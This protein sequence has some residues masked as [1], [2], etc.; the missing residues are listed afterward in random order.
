MR[1]ARR[2]A[3]LIAPAPAAPSQVLFPEV[4]RLTLAAVPPAPHAGS[5]AGADLG[6]AARA[7][8]S[9]CQR[10]HSEEV[11]LFEELGRLLADVRALARRGRRE[12]GGMLGQLVDA[13]RRVCSAISAHIKREESDVLPLLAA[14]LPPQEQRAMV[15]HTLRAMPLR[16]LERVMPWL[17][18][19]LSPADADGLTSS[20]RL[21]APEGDRQVVELLLRW[22]QRGRWASE[23]A[24]GG[25]GGAAAA[26]TGRRASGDG[27]SD[28]S[29]S[30]EVASGSG[31]DGG[32]AGSED[33]GMFAINT[34]G[35]RG[36]GGDG[37]DAPAL[38]KRARGSSG[39]GSGGPGP[40]GGDSGLAAMRPRWLVE[41]HAH[42]H[43]GGCN[44]GTAAAA[45]TDAGGQAGGS[46]A[47]AAAGDSG[48]AASVPE[49]QQQAAA[50]SGPG[51]TLGPK[52][53]SRQR[54]GGG[55][56]GSPRTR[57]PVAAPAQPPPLPPPPRASP[58]G[59][60]KER[61]ASAGVSPIDHIFQF[62]KALRQELR[63]LE[64]DA[65]ELEG[66]VFS[67]PVCGAARQPG[68]GFR[69]RYAG[70][71]QQLDGRFQFLRGIY[72]CGQGLPSP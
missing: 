8:C 11:S 55:G 31:E 32:G 13:A 41:N 65:A 4:F 56:P 44:C 45:S 1:W 7:A 35:L 24:D 57:P 64:A 68:S 23:A 52:P 66:A 46:A 37:A 53:L 40:G 70:A 63:Q 33:P 2:L 67:D 5:A 59:G 28:A 21:A 49:H 25:A 69:R 17:V 26:G 51:A 16:L 18:A 43:G 36:A 22:A 72:R 29:G 50:G 54:S 62:H 9:A 42:S 48:C 58:L 19:K 30:G 34:C 60:V 15:W 20:L 3:S 47:A 10:E 27:G 39:D 61:Q 38:R 6:S 71:L 14:A 12:A